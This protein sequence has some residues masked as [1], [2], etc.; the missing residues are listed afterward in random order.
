MAN[1]VGPRRP[2]VLDLDLLAAPSLRQFR[3]H[4]SAAR[5]WTFSRDPDPPRP[6]HLVGNFYDGHG[7]RIIEKQ[8]S[9]SRTRRHLVGRGRDEPGVRNGFGF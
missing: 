4:Q 3:D 9:A 8:P 7:M 6:K 5:G 2:R 1:G